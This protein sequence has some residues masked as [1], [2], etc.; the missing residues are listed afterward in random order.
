MPMEDHKYHHHLQT[1]KILYLSF[2]SHSKFIF[3]ITHSIKH[4]FQSNGTWNMKME[5]GNYECNESKYN[6][7]APSNETENE[8]LPSFVTIISGLNSLWYIIGAIVVFLCCF[9]C[10]LLYL[11]RRSYRLHRKTAQ[12]LKVAVDELKDFKQMHEILVASKTDPESMLGQNDIAKNISSV[13]SLPMTM[14]P[15]PIQIQQSDASN[16]G[17]QNGNNPWPMIPIPPSNDLDIAMM[18]N[19]DLRAASSPDL[20]EEVCNVLF[21]FYISYYKQSMITI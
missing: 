9:L 18:Q 8:S 1:V 15:T 21:L 3:V 6:Q 13:P 17:P 11:I 12:Q 20:P 7:I 16:I 14:E 5:N 10:L 2:R 4:N 19:R